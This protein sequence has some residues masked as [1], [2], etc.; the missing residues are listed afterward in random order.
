MAATIRDEYQP[1]VRISAQLKG[2][3]FVIHLNNL[4]SLNMKLGGGN[5]MENSGSKT[6]ISFAT[7]HPSSPLARA[8]TSRVIFIQFGR[9]VISNPTSLGSNRAEMFSQG[10]ICSSC[11]MHKDLFCNFL[12]S[13]HP[14]L[15]HGR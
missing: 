7:A 9:I 3:N 11:T 8:K 4:I 12:L 5:H 1:G 14:H 6:K 10:L 2:R 15:T 13:V